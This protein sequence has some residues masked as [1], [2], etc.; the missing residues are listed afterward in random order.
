MDQKRASIMGRLERSVD[1]KLELLRGRL[2]RLRGAQAGNNFGLGVGSRVLYPEH[3]VA[4][5]NV[6]IGDY[7][8]LNCLSRQGVKIGYQTS[9]DRNL[10][11]SC[12]GTYDGTGFFE[13]GDHSYIGCNAVMGAGGGGI[14]IGNN[15]LIGQSVNIHSERHVFQDISVPI[16]MQGISYEG[17]IIED[18]VWV[19]SKA[20]ILDG[21][22]IGTGA[23]IGAGAVVTHSVPPYG[24]VGGV[25]AKIIR[26]REGSREN[27][28]IP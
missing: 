26:V 3:F 12:G 10:W 25:P 2:L 28:H 18:D 27:R 5:D 14:K 20:T 19:G 21:V 4:H 15:V 23:I 16:R 13:I 9:I 17:V 8:Y 6:T 7:S 11:L 24:I 1:R 22:I